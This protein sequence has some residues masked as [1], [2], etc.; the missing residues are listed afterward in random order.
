MAGKRGPTRRD[1]P[2][3]FEE[4]L[5]LKVGGLG[6]L[7]GCCPAT[8]RKVARETVGFPAERIFGRGI[9][10]WSRLEVEAWLVSPTNP[11]AHAVGEREASL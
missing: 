7:L 9:Q 2:V 4:G 10:G 1:K 11:A 5:I 6:R 3:Y 8:A